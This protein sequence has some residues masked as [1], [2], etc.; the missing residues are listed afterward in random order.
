MAPTKRPAAKTTTPGPPARSCVSP[1]L[2][3]EFASRFQGY[4]KAFGRSEVTKADDSGKVGSRNWTERGA[5]TLADYEN[6]LNGVG[7]GLGIIML[8]DDDTCLFG[9]IDCDVRAL[10]HAKAE[11]A[12]TRLGLPLVLCRSKSGGGHFYCFAPEPVEA[13]TLRN[14]LDEWKALLGLAAKTETFPKQDTRFNDNDLGSWINLP[15]YGARDTKRY[16]VLG[17][18]PATL[19]Q[20]LAAVRAAEVAPERLSVP[21]SAAEDLLF[22][23]GPPCLQVLHGQGGF[24]E[25]GRNDGMLAVF[26]YLRKRF[27]DDWEDKADEYNTA[28]AQLP[29]KEL[30]QL[31]KSSGKG[32]GYAHYGCTKPPINAFCQKRLCRTREFGVGGGPD[33]T[34]VYPIGNLT[35]YDSTHGDEPMWAMEVGGKRVMV[36]NS[37]FYSRDEFNRACMAQANLVPI[38][39]PPQKWLKYLGELIATADVMQMPED[40]GPTGQLWEWIE[41][42]TLQRANALTKEEVWLGKPYR[43]EGKVYFRSIDLFRYLDSHKVKY[44]SEQAVWQ[45]LR[46]HGA[47]KE[48]WHVRGK[49]VNVW[50]LEATAPADDPTDAL[51]KASF[52]I[53][54]EAY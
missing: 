34:K 45:L 4:S 2:V 21:A 53:G 29:S 35:R 26:T 19:E 24:L 52:P 38:H 9:A 8:R 37:Q 39:M 33:D 20:F 23:D 3:A 48:A 36:S 49:G 42:F 18:Q 17:G 51:P 5:P 10:D 47:D 22:K 41:G 30:V 1:A 11:A 43:A 46:H 44:K 14:R 27:P 15:Y 25:G 12:I 54:D 28:M 16:A 6:H 31:V 32:K 40:A 50:V 7:P 13:S